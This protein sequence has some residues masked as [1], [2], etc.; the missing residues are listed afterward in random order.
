MQASAAAHACALTHD[1][2]PQRH[3][4]AIAAEGNVKIHQGVGLQS[5]CGVCVWRVWRVCV[6]VWR[7]RGGA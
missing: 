4:I 5:V 6:Y 2:A 7:E 3:G 1:H